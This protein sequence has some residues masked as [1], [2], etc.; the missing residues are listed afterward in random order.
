M[1]TRLLGMVWFVVALLVFGLGVPLAL[2]VAGAEQQRLFLDRLADT[3]RFASMA[4]RPLV[5][6]DPE[7][8]REEL[9]RYSELYGIGVLI[10]DQESSAVVR[11]ASYGSARAVDLGDDQVRDRLQEALAGRRPQPGALLLPWDDKPLVLAGPVLVDGEVRGAVITV[12]PT[13]RSRDRMLWWWLM[14]AAGGVL[15]FAL[16]LML[17]VPVIQWILRPVRRLDEATGSLVAAVVSGREADPVGDEHGPPELRKLSRSFDRMATS[18]GDTLAAQRAFVADASHQLRNPLTALKLR[19]VNLEGHVDTEA[20]DHRVAAAAEADRLKRILDEL[21]ALA[22][23]ENSRGELVPTDVDEVVDERVADWRV[24]AAARDITLDVDGAV[25]PVR[26][27]APARS[28]DGILDALLDNALKFTDPGSQVLVA[29]EVVGDRVR[30]SV[31]DHGPGLRQDEL[32][33]ATDRF[34][35]SNS[36]QNV[37]GSGLGLAIV[38]RVIAHAGGELRLELP[39]G[40][41][42]RVTVELPAEG[43]AFSARK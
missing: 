18:V 21:L 22:R 19:L 33:R 17:A 11:S 8:L 30:L 14:I 25:A 39:D 37:P 29:V 6:G 15:A 43:H 40:G 24:V 20:D 2:A 34:W 26:A 36:H 16:A 7:S 41:G 27:L 31:R 5:D 4:Q 42:L 23:A 35:R 13:D 10:V 1:R 28:V 38:S 32:E 9:N 3:T 12:S